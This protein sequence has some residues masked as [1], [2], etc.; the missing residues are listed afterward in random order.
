[1]AA[2]FIAVRASIVM[3]I[4]NISHCLLKICVLFLYLL[5]DTP[6]CSLVVVLSSL[7]VAVAK[8]LRSKHPV[9]EFFI[10]VCVLQ[11]VIRL[12]I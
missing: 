4:M 8:T 12:A 7:S 10:D 9:S 2:L 5:T 1:M 3:S 11:D 6:Q